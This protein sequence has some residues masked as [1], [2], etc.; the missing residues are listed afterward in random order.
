MTVSTFSFT[1]ADGALL[2]V[3]QPAWSPHPNAAG[4]SATIQ[5][6]AVKP[7]VGTTE[8]YIH[9]ADPGADDYEAEILIRRD[10]AGA[11]GQ[12]GVCIN[13]DPTASTYIMARLNADSL[14]LYQAVAGTLTQ[15]GTSYPLTTLLANVGDSLTLRVGRAA[16]EA[17]MLVNGV[18]RRIGATAVTGRGRVG[19][20]LAG[21]TTSAVG[22]SI[23]LDN[24]LVA[25][26]GPT[27]SAHPS[28]GSYLVGATI[29]L[30]ATP[31]ASSGSITGMLWQVNT[32]SGWADISGETAST[33]TLT[34][35]L[36]QDGNQYRLGAADAAG[37][38][39]SNAATIA[40]AEPDL[41]E[42][43]EYTGTVANQT[44]TVGVA[45]SYD[46]TAL[47]SGNL[48]P[49]SYALT[50]GSLTG[51]GLSLSGGVISG[52][53]TA[54][55]ALSGLVV[56]AT[57]AESNTAST[58]AFSITRVLP[59]APTFDGP[60]SLVVYRPGGFDLSYPAAS[61][62]ATG[63]EVSTN[64]GTSYTSVGTSLAPTIEVALPA[65]PAQVR[66][67]A[68]DTHGQRSSALALPAGVLGSSVPRTGE[69]GPAL[70]YDWLQANPGHDADLVHFHPTSVPADI[71]IWPDSSFEAPTGGTAAGD[72]YVNGVYAASITHTLEHDEEPP[73]YGY[74][75]AAVAVGIAL[76]AMP[77]GYEAPGYAL[78]PE[79]VQ[80]GVQLGAMPWAYEAPAVEV[81][82]YS[83][84]PNTVDIAV[85]LRSMALGYVAPT[86]IDPDGEVFGLL[87]IAQAALYISEY[88]GEDHP[89]L[90]ATPA[91]QAT[92]L[93]QASQY[94]A[95]AYCIKPE[96]LD[97][98]H[99][100]VVAACSE[101]AVRALSGKLYADVKAE[102]VTS[103]KVG[104]IEKTY[105]AVRNGGQT[106]FAVIDALLKGLTCTP[107]GMIRLVRA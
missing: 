46:L 27:W 19:L 45:F 86:P 3:A 22:V 48:F 23:T 5:G 20:R 52:T 7:N 6:N 76:G 64:G 33:L 58:A 30:S 84:A 72:V 78:S 70:L 87:T 18:Q 92:T 13:C 91:R 67:R 93:R 39:Y 37:T 50:S 17:Y 34:A 59:A 100:N 66:V 11:I 57:D 97:P 74:A 36:V 63:Y 101:A 29:T 55:G 75:P 82:E 4:N 1:G 47:F 102:T 107:S 96:C 26:T 80:L 81:P 49:I 69:H 60:V 95:T 83:Y 51:S 35:A 40:V 104:P 43:V 15:I 61:A 98:L 10:V 53:P 8:F 56:T 103:T 90:S 21:S 31:V 54:V 32:G 88:H 105:G 65:N 12:M 24:K 42:P 2:T 94:L 79:A 25:P 16:G 73:E 38:T 68:F 41:D 99:D 28:G 62:S 9:S 71:T 89:W 77:W 106:K 44:A 14:Q 85:L